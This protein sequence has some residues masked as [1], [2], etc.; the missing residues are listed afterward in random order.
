[1][2]L[3]HVPRYAREES[4]EWKTSRGP[5]EVLARS[6]RAPLRRSAA[7]IFREVELERWLTREQGLRPHQARGMVDRLLASTPTIRGAFQRWWLTGR[8]EDVEIQGYSLKRLVREKEMSVLGALLTL[9]L[10]EC[11]DCGVSRDDLDGRP[12]GDL[13]VDAAIDRVEAR[14][15]ARHEGAAAPAA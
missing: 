12:S 3:R 1:M 14:V 6:D 13:R 10:L 5:A 15:A 7:K 11:G 2:V 4:R 9:S 8:I